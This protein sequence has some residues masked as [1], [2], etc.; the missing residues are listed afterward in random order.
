MK[1]VR[2]TKKKLLSMTSEEIEVWKRRKRDIANASHRRWYA[3]RKDD[4]AFKA[5]VAEKSKSRNEWRREWVRKNKERVYAKNKKWRIN[6]RHMAAAQVARHRA[7]KRQAL[8]VLSE[9]DQEQIKKI[10]LYASGLSQLTGVPHHVDHIWPIAKGG[11]HHPDNLRVI[12]AID[13]LQKGC[14]WKWR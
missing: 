4:P 7:R 1:Q 3:L 8:A 2:V 5:A 13:N 11:P 14:G 9:R 6:N 10:F 12:P